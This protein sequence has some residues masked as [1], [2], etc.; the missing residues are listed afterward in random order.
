[1]QLYT[2]ISVLNLSVTAQLPINTWWMLC[3][4]VFW[5][6]KKM[7]RWALSTDHLTRWLGL[8]I[9]KPLNSCKIWEWRLSTVP[10]WRLYA[11]YSAWCSRIF[12][13]HWFIF[14]NV[15]HVWSSILYPPRL[16]PGANLSL[17]PLR[18][19]GWYKAGKVAGVRA[20]AS[21]IIVYI[22][23]MLCCHTSLR[24]QVPS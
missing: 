8:Y 3:V 23:A 24:L 11:L 22:L 16:L 19:L 5:E 7:V 17:K 2:Y 14:Q 21:G 12:G 15:Q 18:Q 6:K 4:C 9:C 13:F 20:V 1:M 10:H